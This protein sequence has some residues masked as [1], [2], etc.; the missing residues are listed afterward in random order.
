MHHTGKTGH[1][2]VSIQKTYSNF[3]KII[4]QKASAVIT[5]QITK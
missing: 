1:L 4:D 5:T 3:V 2:Q